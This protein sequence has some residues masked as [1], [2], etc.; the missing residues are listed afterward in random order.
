MKLLS[1][2]RDEVFSRIVQG[3]T[4]PC[5]DQHVKVHQRP[6]YHIMGAWLIW[7]ARSGTTVHV[8][9]GPNVRGGDFAKLVHWGL[10]APEG[11]VRGRGHSGHWA[12]TGLG[13]AF[14]NG[15]VKVPSHVH[16]YNG[17]IWRKAGVDGFS[18]K[19]VSILDVLGTRHHY[20]ELM[21]LSEHE[22]REQIARI[23]GQVALP[24][25]V[26]AP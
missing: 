10:I 3:S 7:A 18:T 5:C 17:A 22:A 1:E 24:L 12:V 19:M 4:C 16:L 2:A 21:A 20:G 15:E 25:V 8:S 13:H 14:V 6:I 26:V 23:S 9:E 11:G